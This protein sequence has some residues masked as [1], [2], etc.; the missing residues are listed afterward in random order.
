MRGF[1]VFAVL[2]GVLAWGQGTQAQISQGNIV[3]GLDLVADGLTAPVYATHAGDRSGR[4]FIVDQP[5]T[6]HILG[7][8][9]QFNF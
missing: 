4:L 9:M 8:R 6:I 7:L 2:L 3:I 1:I 5:G